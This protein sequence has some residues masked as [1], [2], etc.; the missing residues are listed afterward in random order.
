[1]KLFRLVTNFFSSEGMKNNQ[2]RGTLHFDNSTDHGNDMIKKHQILKSWKCLNRRKQVTNN[3]KQKTNNS[4]IYRNFSVLTHFWLLTRLCFIGSRA[5]AFWFT[6]PFSSWRNPA[7]VGIN[8]DK[9]ASTARAV[10]SK[11]WAEA[12]QAWKRLSQAWS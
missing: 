7:V 9:I 2:I 8:P 10:F 11:M 3:T 6:L 1:M 4:K 5:I 12:L